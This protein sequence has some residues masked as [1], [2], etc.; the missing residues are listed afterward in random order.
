MTTLSRVQQD[1]E[2]QLTLDAIHNALGVNPVTNLSDYNVRYWRPPYGDTNDTLRQYVLDTYG[3]AEA[4]WSIDTNDWDASNDANYIAAVIQN[5]RGHNILMHDAVINSVE[6]VKALNTTLPTLVAQNTTFHTLSQLDALRKQEATA[7]GFSLPKKYSV[8]S[9]TMKR[10]YVPG[11]TYALSCGYIPTSEAAQWSATTGAWIWPASTS[12]TYKYMPINE[13][14]AIVSPRSL[15]SLASTVDDT[16]VLNVSSVLRGHD[17]ASDGDISRVFDESSSKVVYAQGVALPF[18]QTPWPT[19]EQTEMRGA[20]VAPVVINDNVEGT[21]VT[22]LDMLLLLQ[23]VGNTTDLQ[24]SATN[25]LCDEGGLRMSFDKCHT[26]TLQLPGI[27]V[28]N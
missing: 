6:T 10:A 27:E 11:M 20:L 2:I 15:S 26:S 25:E 21:V 14:V 13:A 17:V 7:G 16:E 4:L 22:G 5:A 8:R 24:V 12:P 1:Q 23:S 18:A 19:S 3:L 28:R 9:D